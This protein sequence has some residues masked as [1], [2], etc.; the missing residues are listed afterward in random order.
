MQCKVVQNRAILT[1]ILEANL[2]Q[3]QPLEQQCIG[4]YYALPMATLCGTQVNR[5]GKTGQCLCKFLPSSPDR[6]QATHHAKHASDKN[7]QRDHATD[8]QR[9]RFNLINARHQHRDGG[10]GD[11]HRN[12]LLGDLRPPACAC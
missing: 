5:I 9:L 4:F 8:R 3:T 10:Q 12:K 1:G 6:C 7:V 11:Q 2:L